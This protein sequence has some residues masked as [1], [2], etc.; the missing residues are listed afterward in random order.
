[1]D[2]YR[3][4]RLYLLCKIYY[5][6][7]LQNNLIVF[8]YFEQE[9]PR[10]SIKMCSKLKQAKTGSTATWQGLSLYRCVLCWLFSLNVL[11]FTI[12]SCRMESETPEPQFLQHQTQRVDLHNIGCGRPFTEHW[13]AAYACI[14]WCICSDFL[15]LLCSI[16]QLC[17]YLIK[18]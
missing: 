13:D 15:L 12:L 8:P 10:S 17:L 1:M 3:V 18:R 2:K 16:K 4:F 9:T 14:W 5:I 11:K 6:I 7:P